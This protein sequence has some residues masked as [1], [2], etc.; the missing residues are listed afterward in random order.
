M[1]LATLLLAFAA[2][3]QALQAVPPLTAR[4]IDTTGTL[5][6]AQTAALDGT[7]AALERDKGAQVVVLMVPTTAPED[8]AAYAN[9][10]GNDWKIGRREV[11]DGLILLV[12][13]QDRRVRIEVAK[14][15]EGAVPDIAA[16]RIINDA[17]TPRF[18]Q[19]D[20]AGGLTAGVAQIDARIRGEALPPATQ[21]ANWPWAEGQVVPTVLLG[22]AATIFQWL[23]KGLF[24]V[25]ALLLIAVPVVTAFARGIFGRK[26]GALATGVGMGGLAFWFTASVALA[27]GAGLIGAVYALFASVI[28]TLPQARTGGGR[29]GMF[30][31]PGGGWGG[32]GGFGGGGFGGGGFGSGGGGNFGGG[33]ASGRW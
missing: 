20:F 6:P 23:Q 11:G 25:A 27:L 14:T 22:D 32:G 15:L 21:A 7:L 9:R 10:V 13:L 26:L 31:P 24:H 28:T 19:G 3:A 29:G 1:L 4:V 17:I 12:A 8:I 30:P 18:R 33:G 5:T 16:G 2:Q